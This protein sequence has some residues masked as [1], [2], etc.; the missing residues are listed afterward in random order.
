MKLNTTKFEIGKLDEISQ[1]MRWHRLISELDRFTVETEHHLNWCWHLVHN[2]MYDEAVRKFHA[3]VDR[4]NEDC[5]IA[6]HGRQGAKP[7]TTW[8]DET[9]PNM[10]AGIPESAAEQ[11]K[12][13]GW[14]EIGFT[15]TGV[16]F[17]EQGKR[18]EVS[19]RPRGSHVQLPDGS[20]AVPE[21][22]DTR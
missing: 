13:Q 11:L 16:V 15:D 21:D 3:D 18:G 9:G 8:V 22:P 4:W 10:W 7:T 5:D 6:R 19:A 2:E 1:P 17:K 12:A 20:Y 14:V